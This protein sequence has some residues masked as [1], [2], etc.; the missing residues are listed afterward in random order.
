[1]NTADRSMQYI[2][3][4]GRHR[5]GYSPIYL[6][7]PVDE[8]CQS[9][10][11]PSP[12][13]PFFDFSTDGLRRFTSSPEPIGPHGLMP[14]PTPPIS[15]R[16]DMPKYNTAPSP[17][18]SPWP[19]SSRTPSFVT[20]SGRT[21]SSSSSCSSLSEP[22]DCPQS[23]PA[24]YNPDESEES[25]GGTEGRSTPAAWNAWSIPPVVPQGR[26]DDD[27]LPKTNI[28]LQ[29]VPRIAMPIPLSWSHRGTH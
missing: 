4:Q 20:D 11:R 6:S 22:C 16:H 23:E 2:P 26:H 1:M 25:L 14:S 12:P 8:E 10:S 29:E 18:W 13:M 21:L 9:V 19:I 27:V 5:P 3:L 24:V 7:A 28:P 17:L 15:T